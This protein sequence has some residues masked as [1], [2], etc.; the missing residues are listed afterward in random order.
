MIYINLRKIRIEKNL[1]QKILAAM[2]EVS[3]NY[4]SE[5][6][7]GQKMPSIGKLEKIAEVLG[8]SVH[9]SFQ[10]KRT[11]IKIEGPFIKKNR[12]RKKGGAEIR[13]EYQ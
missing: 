1:S 12:L 7:N 5:I 9:I 3:Q 4:L 13:C 2:A 6:E 10:G 8:C 11:G